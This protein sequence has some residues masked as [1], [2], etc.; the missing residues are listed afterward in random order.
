MKVGDRGGGAWRLATHYGITADDIDNALG[1][2]EA[3]FRE[4]AAR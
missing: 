1:V 4:H 2:V 3:V